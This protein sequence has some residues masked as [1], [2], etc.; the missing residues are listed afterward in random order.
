MKQII[1]I[2]HAKVQ[3]DKSTPITAKMLK[4]WETAYNNAPIY[5]ELPQ[6]DVLHQ[7]FSEVDYVVCSTLRRTIDSVELLGI[8]VDESNALFNE[9]TIPTLEG[10]WL[11]LR[12]TQWLV[13]FRILSLFGIGR[14]ARTLKE[15][16]ADAYQ[17]SQRLLELS[18]EHQTII[19]MGHGVMNWLIRKEMMKEGWRSNGK[20][21]HGNWGMTTLTYG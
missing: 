11:K 8:T 18:T 21:A 4:R 14:W 10:N 1:F 15:T 12:P 3:M 19:L 20:D 16:K 9:A 7:A 2:R 17:A 5:Q 6:N 13:L